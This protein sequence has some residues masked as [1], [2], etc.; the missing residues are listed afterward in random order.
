MVS[1]EQ[2]MRSRKDL[3]KNMFPHVHP[4]NLEKQSC[5]KPN[6]INHPQVI[7]KSSPFWVLCLPSPNSRFIGLMWD[8]SRLHLDQSPHNK[9]RKKS[10]QSN[11]TDFL[12]CRSNLGECLQIHRLHNCYSSLSYLKNSQ[13]ILVAKSSARTTRIS[14]VCQL[15][16]CEIRLIKLCV[17][18]EVTWKE[19]PTCSGPPANQWK[20]PT[21]NLYLIKQSQT[22]GLCN[23]RNDHKRSSGTT[24][25]L[26]SRLC[27]CLPSFWRVIHVSL[28]CH[29]G[30]I[31]SSDPVWCRS[32]VGQQAKI[33][34]KW[35][36]DWY[37]S[38]CEANR[39]QQVWDHISFGV[40]KSCR[41]PSTAVLLA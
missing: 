19:Y 41:L 20:S 31:H 12:R 28:S 6:F 4:V 26:E 22:S 24:R 33:G 40:P 5:G 30:A 1:R 34:A 11:S 7:T 14:R 25:Q 39:F 27:L 10:P 16:S 21:L 2:V 35:C 8:E 3:S 37:R 15:H 9:C 23:R 36:K 32:W 13:V 17:S 29:P 18:K 38:K